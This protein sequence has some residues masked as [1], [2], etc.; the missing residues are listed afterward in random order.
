MPNEICCPPFSVCIPNNTL[1][2][3]THYTIQ[4]DTNSIVTVYKHNIMIEFM[5]II[6]V[7]QFFL[8]FSITPV[9]QCCVMKTLQI[10]TSYTNTIM[11]RQTKI[12]MSSRTKF[13]GFG[14]TFPYSAK[15]H[16]PTP[17]TLLCL[18]SVNQ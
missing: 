7:E 13:T 1:K 18:T 5:Y 2:P 9:I 6:Y 17:T 10:F 16:F 3:N 12:S 8:I 4:W 11:E 15:H 14:F